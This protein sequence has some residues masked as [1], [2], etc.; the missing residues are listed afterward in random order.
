MLIG[1][2]LDEEIAE[3]EL[4]I[5]Q[6]TDRIQRKASEVAGVLRDNLTSPAILLLATGVGF[7]LGTFTGGDQPRGQTR[8]ERAF[9]SVYRSVQAALQIVRAPTLVW[10]ARLLGNQ[11]KDGPPS[12]PNRRDTSQ[13][14]SV[15]KRESADSKA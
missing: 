4:R 7:A 5:Q 11:R 3:V 14:A 1:P 12:P 13:L 10:L 15:K 6:R 2:D 8:L 9:A